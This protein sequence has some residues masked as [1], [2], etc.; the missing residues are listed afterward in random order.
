MLRWSWYWYEPGST[1]VLSTV[2][3]FMDSLVCALPR[4]QFF[5]HIEAEN[6][7]Q[8]ALERQQWRAYAGSLA[9]TGARGSI[10]L[11]W[12]KYVSILFCFKFADLCNS[13][14]SPQHH[15]SFPCHSHAECSYSLREFLCLV[16]IISSRRLREMPFQWGSGEFCSWTHL[17]RWK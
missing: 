6:T 5:I 1:S 9:D 4:I 13:S 10:S 11:V 2:C 8:R 14:P 7:Q 16:Y 12:Y 17:F 15:I 3:V